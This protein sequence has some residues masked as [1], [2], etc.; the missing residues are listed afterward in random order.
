MAP[1]PRLLRS[2]HH[3][4]QPGNVG[5]AQPGNIVEPGN[6]AEQ[7]VASADDIVKAGIAGRWRLVQAVE[8]GR[9]KAQLVGMRTLQP[10]PGTQP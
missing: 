10:R 1:G 9:G 3:R 4:I 6:R 5:S 7:S 2:L 8:A